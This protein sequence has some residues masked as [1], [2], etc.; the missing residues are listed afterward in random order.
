MGKQTPNSNTQKFNRKVIG[1]RKKVHPEK[2]SMIGQWPV[3]SEIWGIGD[4]YIPDTTKK[5]AF[6]PLLEFWKVFTSTH[7]EF[8]G[9][10]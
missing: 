2:S 4:F 3:C 8:R 10:K 6:R 1:L 7:L 5:F 9:F